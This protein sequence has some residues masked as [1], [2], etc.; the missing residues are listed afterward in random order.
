MCGTEISKIIAS[1]RRFYFC[2]EC[3]S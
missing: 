3:Q 2:P 1:S